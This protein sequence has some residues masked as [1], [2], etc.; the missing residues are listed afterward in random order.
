MTT[1]DTNPQNDVAQ[2]VRTS[3]AGAGTVREASMFGGLAFMVDDR[4]VVSVGGSGD[5][6]V[7][8]DPAR[9]D[10]LCRQGGEPASMGSDRPMGQ[11]WLTVPAR[12]IASDD[13]LVFW[14]HTGL[15]SRS[16]PR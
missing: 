1:S 3:L 8:T 15:E 6:L 9:Y 12:R 10:D 11:G 4:L 5:L 13:D 2:R 7:R 14:I 16:S